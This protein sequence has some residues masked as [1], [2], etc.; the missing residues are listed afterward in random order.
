M[1][2]K[3]LSADQIV[4]QSLGLLQRELVVPR[5]FWNA[6]D[7]FARRRPGRKDDT[8]NL[9]I[10]AVVKARDYEWRTRTAP[11]VVDEVEE[12][13][14]PI[15]LNRHGYAAFALTDEEMT[16]DIATFGEQVTAPRVRAIAEQA[17]DWAVDA[18]RAAPFSKAIAWNVN[19]TP[20]Y[21]FTT[22]LR[23]AFNDAKLPKSDRIVL[24]GSGV[25]EAVL[26]DDHLHRYEAGGEASAF[27]DAV[28]GQIGG[29]TFAQVDSLEPG[30]VF[31]YHRSAMA[32]VNLAPEVPD[33]VNYGAIQSAYGMSMRFIRD[34]DTNFLRDRGVFSHFAGYS[35]V[36][37]E[38]ELDGDGMPGDFTGKN[39]RG[40]KITTSNVPA[41]AAVASV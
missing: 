16:L 10:P 13:T 26:N 40:F 9:P 31:A 7:Y 30:E 24:I 33:G 18:L 39:Q 6:T 4:M 27:R 17:E 32:R 38:R 2:N 34:Y 25:E 28:I 37:D 19:T 41:A 11:I 21:Q 5:F 35:S 23:R 29:F 20:A 12:T 36:N 15:R 3:W 1:A 22:K 14:V 8:V